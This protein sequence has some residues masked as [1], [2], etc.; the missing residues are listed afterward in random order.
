MLNSSLYKNSGYYL[1]DWFKDKG[2]R[3]FPKVV[4]EQSD[5]DPSPLASWSLVKHFS[6][7]DTGTTLS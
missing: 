7:Y 4:S 3:G 6:H 2:F 5:G 1:T